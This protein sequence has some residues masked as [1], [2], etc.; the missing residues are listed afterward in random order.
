[1]DKE[2]KIIR[3]NELLPQLSQQEKIGAIYQ[4]S[5]ELSE[6]ISTDKED[7]F[8]ETCFS[9]KDEQVRIDAIKL[10]SSDLVK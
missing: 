2:D 5:W 10:L 4:I 3:L 7:E 8:V 1:M 6:D 9:L